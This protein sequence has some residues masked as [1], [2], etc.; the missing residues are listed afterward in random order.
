[1]PQPRYSALDSLVMFLSEEVVDGRYAAG[2]R[3]VEDEIAVA[4]GVSRSTVRAA[5]RVL[6]AR[7]MIT[8]GGRR[9][10]RVVEIDDGDAAELLRLRGILEPMLI[11]KFTE[12]ASAR[13]VDALERTM[14][15]FAETALTSDEL[16]RVHRARDSFYEVLFDGAASSMLEQTVRAEYTKLAAYRRSRFSRERELARIRANARSI[17][18][19]LPR[20][21]HREGTAAGVYS[22][23]MLGQDGAATLR[24]LRGEAVEDANAL[25]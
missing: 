17:L 20:I 11:H 21:L 16:R 10:G 24:F 25:V 5:L 7:G 22:H 3:L 23:R 2:D 8:L 6:A 9:G 13:Q 15:G 12:R 1:M 18:G 19:V 14:T 4:Y